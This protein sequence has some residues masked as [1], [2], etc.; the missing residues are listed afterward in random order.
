VQ[1]SRDFPPDKDNFIK[2][3]EEFINVHR[4]RLPNADTSPLLFLTKGGKPFTASH[5][6]KEVTTAVQRR[7]G[8]LFFPHISRTILA[9]MLLE[10]GLPYATVGSVLGDTAVT[11]AKAY[12]HIEPQKHLALAA[13]QIHEALGGAL[14]TG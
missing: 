2:A 1:L 7:T 6:A 8:V 11:V 9:T 13:S 10:K 3:L 4:K 5:L 14:R 12:H